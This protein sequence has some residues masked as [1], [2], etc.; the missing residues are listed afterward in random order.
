[1][2]LLMNPL[3]RRRRRLDDMDDGALLALARAGQEEAFSELFERHSDGVFRYAVVRLRSRDAALDV[4]SYVFGE[5]WR[6]RHAIEPQGGSLRPWLFAVTRNCTARQVANHLKGSRIGEPS[7]QRSEDHAERV[8]ERIDASVLF[9]DVLEAIDKLSAGAREALTLH[10]WGG[11]TY[12]EIASELG[13]EVGT[14]KSRLNR[15]R[16]RLA[17]S[18]RQS[19]TG[20]SEDNVLELFD[21]ERHR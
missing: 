1:M 7:E 15:A 18:M 16:Q 4:V 10:V 13:V 5:A 19:T 17:A 9:A 3:P 20:R 12:E 21:P 8:A 6:Q 11:M 2:Y 14:V